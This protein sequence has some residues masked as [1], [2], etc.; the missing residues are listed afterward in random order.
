MIFN[1]YE[2][3]TASTEQMLMPPLLM[4][5]LTT[6]PTTTPI[7]INGFDGDY[8]AKSRGLIAHFHTLINTHIYSVYSLVFL[9]KIV[10]CQDPKL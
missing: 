2:Y 6:T 8:S 10:A 3:F 9:L 1:S 5:T 7:M 4:T